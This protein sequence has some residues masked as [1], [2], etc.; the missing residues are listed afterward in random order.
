M[1]ALFCDET[2]LNQLS[3][4]KFLIYGGIF[5]DLGR[6][7]NLHERVGIIRRNAGYRPE[8]VF[9]FNTKERPPH[10]PQERFLT[11]KNDILLMCQ[12]LDIRF[13]VHVIL[14][15]IIAKQNQAQQVSWA[16]D[17]VIS[18]FHEFL[19]L[20]NV[21]GIV[22]TDPLPFHKGWQYL[23]D[24]FRVGLKLDDG[25]TISLER[26]KLFSSS[27]IGASHAGS[28]IDIVLGSFRYCINEPANLTAASE[29]IRR[30]VRLMWHRRLADGTITVRDRGLIL[31]PET[32]RVQKYQ[33]EYDSLLDRLRVLL[34]EPQQT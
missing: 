34:G 1:Y 11:A 16:A 29:M 28:V 32:V 3:N 12:E 5:F 9:K 7:S 27:C 6:L 18:R 14:H 19:C 22:V 13:I 33:K 8:D 15:D 17:Y 2:N 21:D 20:N 10:V 4:V 23:S 24:K 31:R 26:I 30:V 25:R